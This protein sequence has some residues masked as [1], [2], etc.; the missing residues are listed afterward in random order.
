MLNDKGELPK[1]GDKIKL[2][3]LA[4]TLAIISENPEALYNGPLTA[5]FVKDIQ[6]DGG[7]I[8]AEDMNSYK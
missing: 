1:Y 4:E 7:I 5:G 2:P 3:K 6:D 8:T